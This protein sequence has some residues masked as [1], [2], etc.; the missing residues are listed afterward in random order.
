M[1]ANASEQ[2]LMRA[3]LHSDYMYMENLSVASL[4]SGGKPT[5]DLKPS[6]L[7]NNLHGNLEAYSHQFPV[8]KAFLNELYD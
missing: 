6:C 5:H 1:N 2:T 4:S 7:A 8:N 3:L